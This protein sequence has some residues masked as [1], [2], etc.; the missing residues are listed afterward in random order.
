MMLFYREKYHRNLLPHIADT[1][2][3]EL[4]PQSI[5]RLRFKVNC[6]V[7]FGKTKVADVSVIHI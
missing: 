7:D 6:S 5:D 1:L 3:L 4:L 2:L